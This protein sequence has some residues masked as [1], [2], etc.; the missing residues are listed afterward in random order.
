[1]AMSEKDK[2]DA[3]NAFEGLKEVWPAPVTEI[4]G[5]LSKIQAT[6]ER[7]HEVM[8]F[9]VEHFV[10]T[11]PQIGECQLGDECWEERCAN[12]HRPL[13]AGHDIFWWGAEHG[14]HRAGAA[15]C[16]EACARKVVF[17]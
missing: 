5:N 1:M 14:E 12:C 16:D 6:N 4:L 17:G 13:S 8:L 9:L 2:Q 11:A 3:I 15:V 10:E 7:A